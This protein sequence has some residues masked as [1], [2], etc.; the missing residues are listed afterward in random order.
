MEL[1]TAFGDRH[2]LSLMHPGV[3]AAELTRPMGGMTVRDG[4]PVSSTTPSAAE[5]REEAG[6]TA[7]SPQPDE[8]A[9]TPSPDDAT[10]QDNTAEPSTVTDLPV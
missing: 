5:D 7:S 8:T 2:W 9:A 4:I 6:V 3:A 10:P 1:T